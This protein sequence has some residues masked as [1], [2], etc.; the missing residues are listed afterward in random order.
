MV[1]K[2]KLP[3]TIRKV[4]VDRKQE[5]KTTKDQMCPLYEQ[6]IGLLAHMSRSE[7][8]CLKFN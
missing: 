8:K 7:A 1:D 4:Q 6:V 3:K 5:H 2:T